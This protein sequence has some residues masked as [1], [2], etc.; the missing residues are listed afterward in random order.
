[1]SS[2]L[3]IKRSLNV[4]KLRFTYLMIQS[5]PFYNLT[6]VTKE[7]INTKSI[8]VNKRYLLNFFGISKIAFKR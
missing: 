5:S 3:N 4:R 7:I 2:S 1:M 6:F 8:Q